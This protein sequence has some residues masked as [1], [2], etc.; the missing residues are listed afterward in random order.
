MEVRQSDA[1]AWAEIWLP[2][3]G[4]IR[5]DPTAAIAPGR[6][7]AGLAATVRSGDALPFFARTDLA[8]L[9][10]LRYN[11]DALANAWNQSVLG[12][13]PDRQREV[14]LHFGMEPDWMN[15]TVA[16]TLSCFCLLQGFTLFMMR[17][18]RATDPVLR[19]YLA[20]C[21]RLA[22]R[23]VERRIDEGPQDFARRAAAAL[24]QYARDIG[25]ISARYID[26]RYGRPAAGD[27]AARQ[28]VAAFKSEL[29]QSPL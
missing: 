8:W 4:W 24:P 11:W 20:F 21:A 27:T 12:F 15:M 29:A 14:L 17:R 22:R 7:E 1:H 2:D 9:R 6:V 19:I 5:V 10:E 25:A 3:D 23:G 18:Y 28:D 16:L 13:N 26:L